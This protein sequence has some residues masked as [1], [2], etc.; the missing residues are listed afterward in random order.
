MSGCP[1]SQ[2][3]T[4]TK[5]AM[6]SVTSLGIFPAEDD[7]HFLSGWPDRQFVT[8]TKQAVSSVTSLGIFPAEGNQHFLSGGP[9]GQFRTYIVSD[10]YA[11]GGSPVS[12]LRKVTGIFCPDARTGNFARTLYLIYTPLGVARY[13]PCG[14]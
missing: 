8:H 9:D 4:H 1:D 2:F 11:L 5:Q 14:R 7:R 13:L 10:L 3:V 12:S 6:S